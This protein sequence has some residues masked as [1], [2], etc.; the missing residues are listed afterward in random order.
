MSYQDIK[1]EVDTDNRLGGR[2]QSD[3]QASQ[4]MGNNFMPISQKDDAGDPTSVDLKCL[5]VSR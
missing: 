5:D 4:W 3:K 2:H 1:G